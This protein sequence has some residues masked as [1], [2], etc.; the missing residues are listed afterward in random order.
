MSDQMARSG[1]SLSLLPA[2]D[3]FGGNWNLTSSNF[4]PD[5]HASS[6][7]HATQHCFCK[8]VFLQMEAIRKRFSARNPL[9]RQIPA[10]ATIL[11]PPAPPQ[12]TPPIRLEILP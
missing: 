6:C 1:G 9:S 11:K 7:K 4:V 2:S 10:S 12:T 5:Q 3:K 8:R